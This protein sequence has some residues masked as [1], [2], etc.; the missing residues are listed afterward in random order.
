VAAR[1]EPG[2]VLTVSGAGGAYRP[3]PASDWHLLAGRTEDV[4]QSEKRQPIGQI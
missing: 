4:F 2:D 1:A 3:D